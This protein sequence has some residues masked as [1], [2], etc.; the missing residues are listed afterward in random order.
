MKKINF[1][2]RY[3]AFFLSVTVFTSIVTSCKE[4][5]DDIV[6]PKTITDVIMQNDEF[7]ILREIILDNNLSD[8]FR[9]ENLT[10][11]AP[12]NAAFI[13]SSVT[14]AMVNALPDSLARKFVFKHSLKG[15]IRYEEL[16][17][18]T[19]DGYI[20]G[21]SLIVKKAS[22]SDTSL[23]INGAT[24]STKN[25]NADNGIIQVVSRVLVPVR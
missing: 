3:V 8:E 21:D 9:T 18:Q 7:S 16:K 6:K 13:N 14:A 24:V 2:G 22:I 12:N 17:E 4:N 15:K 23:T 19:Y 1:I 5:D 11:F 10:L 20:A 25:I